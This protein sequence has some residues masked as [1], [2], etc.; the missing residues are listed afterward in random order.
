MI[1]WGKRCDRLGRPARFTSLPLLV[2]GVA[3]AASAFLTAAPWLGYLG[4]C[5]C[6]IGVLAAFPAA[7]NSVHRAEAAR[8]TTSCAQPQPSVMP[9]PPC[10]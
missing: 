5:A 1:Y 10:P 2:G 7:A 3:L 8:A 6:A 9:E 4:V